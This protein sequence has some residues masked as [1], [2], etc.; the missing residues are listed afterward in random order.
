MPS[1][2]S[3]PRFALSHRAGSQASLVAAVWAVVLVCAT[4]ASIAAALSTAGYDHGLS[5]AVAQLD[6]SPDGTDITNVLVATSD[7]TAANDLTARQA[8]DATTAALRDVAGDYD[9]DMSMWVAGPMT[10]IGDDVPRRGYFLDADTARDNGTIADGR[11]P[12]T[13]A[14]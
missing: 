3:R 1:A 6:T 12:E 7:G 2:A 11:W 14:D 9:S 5:A 4:L 8:V 13:V 10:Q